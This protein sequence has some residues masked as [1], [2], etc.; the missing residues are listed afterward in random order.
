MPVSYQIP[1]QSRFIATANIF[2]AVFNA[3]T[4]GKYDIT[5]TPGNQNVL[6][7]DLQ[8]NT[9]YFIDSLSVSGNVTEQQYLE[10]IE[11][12]PILYVKKKI[13]GENVY[14]LPIPIANYYDGNNTSAWVF[15]DKHSDQLLFTL[16]GLLGQ[17]ASMVGVAEVKIQIS[18]NIFAIESSYFNGAFRD[19]LANSIGQSNRR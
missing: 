12:F 7:I 9:V 4:P 10:S 1:T 6:C 3:I 14:Q 11:V 19:Q 18:M 16:Q 13:R 2:S 5:N 17:P 15:S 8:P